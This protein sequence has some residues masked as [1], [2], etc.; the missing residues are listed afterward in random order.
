ME[1]YLLTIGKLEPSYVIQKAGFHSP[2]F[3]L[4]LFLDAQC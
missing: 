2:F 3:F 4:V 1:Q